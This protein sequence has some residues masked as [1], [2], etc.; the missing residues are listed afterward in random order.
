MNKKALALSILRDNISV[1]LKS[2]K[3]D[4]ENK[5]LALFGVTRLVPEDIE[6]LMKRLNDVFNEFTKCDAADGLTYTLNL[7]LYPNDI[8][9]LALTGEEIIL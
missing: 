6:K 2:V 1:A 7:S 9:R 8:D 5:V 3:D 4:D